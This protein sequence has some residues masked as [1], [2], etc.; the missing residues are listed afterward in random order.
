MWV[1][2]NDNADYRPNNC[3]RRSNLLRITAYIPETN[4]QSISQRNKPITAIFV[5]HTLDTYL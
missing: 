1:I 4:Y 3:F 2:E 5:S